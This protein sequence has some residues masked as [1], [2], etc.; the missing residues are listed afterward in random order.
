VGSARRARRA[1][2]A[3][4][5]EPG[6]ISYEELL[7][8]EERAATGVPP[9]RGRPTLASDRTGTFAAGGR[10]SGGERLHRNMVKTRDHDPDG[11]PERTPIPA[12]AE[13]GAWRWQDPDGDAEG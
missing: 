13:P 7:A 4:Y 9:K 1:S 8:D 12:G 6:E 3:S 10:R 5:Y 11:E 2:A